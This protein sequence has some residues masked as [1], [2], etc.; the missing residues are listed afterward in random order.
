MSFEDILL[1]EPNGGNK[2]DES[3]LNNKEQQRTLKAFS[4]K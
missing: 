4:L 1:I 3:L 2:R